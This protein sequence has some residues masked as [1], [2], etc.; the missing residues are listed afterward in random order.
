MLTKHLDY[1][2][3]I[4]SSGLEDDDFFEFA[5]LASTF[6]KDLANDIIMPGAFAQTLK[7]KMPVLLFQ[8]SSSE[9]IG[10]VK[11]AKETDRGLEIVGKLPLDDSLVSG[12]VIPQ[13][14][15]GSIKSMSIGFTMS[16]DDFEFNSS[17]GVTKI[18]SLNLHEISLVTFPANP[19][20]KITDFKS[21]SV[22]DI[23]HI[24]T[25]R[26]LEEFLRDACKFSRKAACYLASKVDFAVEDKR[27]IR[28]IDE[29]IE[30]IQNGNRNRKQRIRQRRCK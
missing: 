28:K 6:K 5:G 9:P 22:D 19:G 8:H 11:K 3:E 10:I 7:K 18:N 14:K 20:A 21:I 17:T 4:K 13:I 16:D 25:K 29:I 15:V 2:L 30:G 24:K 23:T 26:I 1:E 27:I 12:R